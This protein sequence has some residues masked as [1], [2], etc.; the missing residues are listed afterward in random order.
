MAQ[1]KYLL[2][3]DSRARLAAL[4]S[5]HNQPPTEPTRRQPG[6]ADSRNPR[7]RKGQRRSAPAK[8]GADAAGKPVPRE[9]QR[10]GGT[11]EGIRELRISSSKPVE[12]RAT[13]AR[14]LM[15]AL[16]ELD[17]DVRRA[18]QWP[19]DLG[20]ATQFQKRAR[21]LHS[22][23]ESLGRDDIAVK[24][25]VL[26]MSVAAYYEVALKRTSATPL[27]RTPRRIQGAQ[28][29]ARPL[30]EITPGPRHAEYYDDPTLSK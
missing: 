22:R 5:E 12:G 13:Q 2:D 19:A 23:A 6:S 10:E 15:N 17:K 26:L 27:I 25:A 16:R 29:P 14:T 9:R 18:R 21:K 11:S 28:S 4:A 30:P 7:R 20:M 24:C 8:G 1:L 3:G